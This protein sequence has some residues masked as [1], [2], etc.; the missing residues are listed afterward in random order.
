MKTAVNRERQ[1]ALHVLT[2]A[3]AYS[4]SLV[5]LCWRFLKQWGAKGP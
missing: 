3:A 1:R 5:A 4:K 2:N